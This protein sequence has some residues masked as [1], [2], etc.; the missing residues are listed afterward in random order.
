M[1]R[2]VKLFFAMFALC[3]ATTACDSDDD[4]VVDTSPSVSMTLSVDLEDVDW[5][6]VAS[7]DY[8]LRVVTELYSDYGDTFVAR[9][10]KYITSDATTSL[11]FN[12]SLTEKDDFRSC[13][14]CD[15][16]EA[17][18]HADLA[19]SASS[20][21]N[22]VRGGS[23]ELS[24][25]LRKSFYGYGNANMVTVGG[26]SFS[27]EVEACAKEVEASVMTEETGWDYMQVTYTSIPTQFNVATDNV[28][29]SKSMSFRYTPATPAA[30]TF[31][32]TDYIIKASG[33]YSATVKFYSNSGSRVDTQDVTFNKK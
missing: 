13:V 15:F 26:S 16:V 5:T 10:V 14:W 20:L 22:V 31:D 8:D 28:T 25:L 1:N 6:D 11:D 30:D 18:A 29:A 23:S 24:A 27:V 2:I 7:A 9:E 32:L 12:F 4:E 33:S 3:V 19:Y 17:G 21:D